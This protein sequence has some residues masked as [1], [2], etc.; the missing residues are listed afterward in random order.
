[1]QG[2]RRVDTAPEVNLRRALHA[3]GLRFRKDLIVR[4]AD[5]KAKEVVRI[6]VELR[7]RSPLDDHTV[8]ASATS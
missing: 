7:R 5:A 2:N 3:S 4:G 1:M 6:P 8:T